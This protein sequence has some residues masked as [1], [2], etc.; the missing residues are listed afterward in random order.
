VRWL[1]G[2]DHAETEPESARSAPSDALRADIVDAATQLFRTRGFE[3]VTMED[4]ARTVGATPEHVQAAFECPRELFA[5]VF[6]REMAALSRRLVAG[7][8]SQDPVEMMRSALDRWVDE[9]TD[10][11]LRQ[12]IVLDAPDVLGWRRWRV[13]ADPY[14]R[15]LIS[16]ALA[17]AMDRGSMPEQPVRPLGYIL[18]GAL[19]SAIQYAARQ[20]EP[21][22]ALETARGTLHS[23]LEA[24]VS[25]RPA[26]QPSGDAERP[27]TD[28]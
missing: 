12:V 23:I 20:P 4:V 24:L 19:D 28:R 10:P 14:G 18:A 17:D 3:A 26:D 27:G 16:A 25:H 13:A 6:D 5:E 1:R 15:M 7:F 8:T 21:E 11:G 2:R 22:V 9:M